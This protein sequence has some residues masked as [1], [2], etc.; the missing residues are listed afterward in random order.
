MNQQKHEN[1][2]N[3]NNKM[4]ILTVNIIKNIADNTILSQYYKI[5][6]KKLS[7]RRKNQKKKDKSIFKNQCMIH[8]GSKKKNKY[9]FLMIL[10]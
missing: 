9:N 2:Q 8:F 5:N 7:S 4:N 3:K 1:N 10:L 6:K